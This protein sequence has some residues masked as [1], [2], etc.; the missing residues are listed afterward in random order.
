MDAVL[1]RRFV[2]FYAKSQLKLKYRYTSLGFLW[3]FLEPALFLTVLSVVFSVVNKMDI[4]D[5]A[6]F[7]FGALMPWRYFEKVVNTCM[8]S[9]VGGDWL[10]KKIYVSAYALPLTR[11]VIAS[12]EFFFSLSVVFLFFALLKHSFTIH[13]LVLPLAVVPW[14]LLGLGIGLIAAVLFTFFR[15][16]RT[17]VQM[18]L[19]LAF[20]SSP[21]LFN[22]DMFPP[23]SLQA[24]LVALH[25]IT[26]FAALFQKPIYFATWPAPIDW[27][28]SFGFATF[29]L[30]LGLYAVNKYKSRFYFYL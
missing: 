8:D 28:I 16:V 15:D 25:P 20:F 24:R 14:G 2:W 29:A 17:I 13:L 12:V 1:T 11:W 9:I 10:L 19:M 7:L 3:N 6:V 4:T 5:Y 30:L 18:V 27:F 22:P 21:I 26:Y 23:G